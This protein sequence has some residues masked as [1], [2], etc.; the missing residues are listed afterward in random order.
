MTDSLA[1]FDPDLC[2]SWL[3]EVGSGRLDR[4]RRDIAWA[5]WTTPGDASQWIE[6]LEAMGFLRLDRT[7][8]TWQA[9]PLALTPLPGETQVTLITGA[10]PTLENWTDLPGLVV[11]QHRQ[12]TPI[13][14]PSTVWFQGHEEQAQSALGVELARCAAEQIADELPPLKLGQPGSGPARNTE[15]TVFDKFSGQFRKSRPDPIPSPGL[16]RYLLHG[17]IPQYVLLR[18]R[19]WYPIGRDEGIHLSLSSTTYP[20][21]WQADQAEGTRQG[22][23]RLTIDHRTPLPRRHR[24]AAVLCTGLPPLRVTGGLAYDGVPRQIAEKIATSLHRKVEIQ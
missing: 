24:E 13:L 18:D 16:Y 2:V 15:L 7:A 9:R 17:R 6:L 21:R 5:A 12:E 8:R 10:R 14:P 19:H 23:G 20:L 11:C 1:E 22:T 4:L 3:A